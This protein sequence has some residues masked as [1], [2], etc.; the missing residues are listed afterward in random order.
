MAMKNTPARFEL[1]PSSRNDW[2]RFNGFQIGSPL[3]ITVDEDDT[4]M[5]MNEVMANPIGI[6]NN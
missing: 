1:V 4:M 6:V 3:K 5:P 2:S